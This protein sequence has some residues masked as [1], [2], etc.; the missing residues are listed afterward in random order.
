MAIR[1]PALLWFLTGVVVSR[2]SGSSELFGARDR[3]PVFSSSSH[4]SVPRAF[5]EVGYNQGAMTG[6]LR[7]LDRISIHMMYAKS[8][9][10]CEV[11]NV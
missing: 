2:V 3:P 9:E 8:R 11:P 4:M 6:C 7:R 10:T 1:P 5:R